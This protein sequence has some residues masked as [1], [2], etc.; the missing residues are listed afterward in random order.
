MGSQTAAGSSLALSAM[1]PSSFDAAGYVALT[2]VEIG[3]VEKLGS[4]GASF[5]KVE[6]Q[7]LKGAKQKFKGSADF[8]ALQPSIALDALDAGQILLQTASDDETQK[9]YSFRVTFPD[10]SA[11][12]FRGR[13]FG[14]PET[15]DGADSMLMATPTVEI[16]S[17]VVKVD[18]GATITPSPTLSK[19]SISP[20]SGAVGTTFT[21]SDGAVTN[22]TITGRRWLLGTTAI[23]TGT[24]VTPNAAGSLTRENTAVG[25]NGETVTS[26]STAVTV[27]AVAT[28]TL[29]L[30]PANPS[31][32]SSVAAGTLISNIA[33]V[34]SGVTPTVTPNDGRLVIAG[35]ASAGWKVVRGM[36]ALSAGTVNFSVAATGATGASGV[37]TVTAAS[38]LRAMSLAGNTYSADRSPTGTTVGAVMGLEQDATIELV[39][40]L[41]GAFAIAN[42]E[43]VIGATPA[44]TRQS[45][46]LQV[47]KTVGSLT[48]TD[49]LTVDGPI[50]VIAADTFP[51][52]AGTALETRTTT[53]GAKQWTSSVAGLFA[54]DGAGVLKPTAQTSGA[55]ATI[56]TG[57]LTHTVQAKVSTYFTSTAIF[58]MAEVVAA[59]ADANNYWTAR[60]DARY[61]RIILLQK[62]GGNEFSV[63]MSLYTLTSGQLIDIGL[64]VDA[65]EIAL[66]VNGKEV[67]WYPRGTPVANS[68]G[69]GIRVQ[70]AA[71]ATDYAT[72]RE[73]AVSTP[74]GIKIAWPEFTITNPATA[75]IDTGP[76]GSY[77]NGDANNP[78][79]APVRDPVTG[80]WVMSYSGYPT[81]GSGGDEIQHLCLARADNIDGPWTK[82]PNNPVMLA[83]PTIDGKWAFNGGFVYSAVS[84]LWVLTYGT[85]AGS[86]VAWATSPDLVTWTR[87]GKLF[88]KGTAGTWFQSG[89]F[90]SSLRVLDDGRIEC[91][92]AAKENG[93][94]FNFGRAFSSDGGLTWAIPNPAQFSSDQRLLAVFGNGSMF[95]SIIGEPCY[96]SPPSEPQQI[97]CTFD[98][99]GLGL[100][101]QPLGGRRIHGSVSFD[102]GK[103]W[104][105]RLQVRSIQASSWL[106]GMTIDSHVYNRPDGLLGMYMGATTVATTS[107]LGGGI[108]IGGSKTSTPFTSVGAAS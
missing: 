104:R 62:Q 31:V 75:D 53:A 19:P 88:A 107:P 55:F 94:G 41:G 34:P 80:K 44:L 78:A 81:R 96:V 33:N 47:R 11:R 45:R 48:R 70:A 82:D 49:T 24:T 8:G 72:W 90:D 3:Q 27:S 103:T 85:S 99:Q 26:T 38:T 58:S 91:V 65:K 71:S 28:P 86:E 68:T 16:C 79:M 64:R 76:A 17:K 22:G 67:M 52:T 42:N 46:A 9:L 59:Y 23:G 102:G 63:A 66:M 13:V 95:H 12:Y 18:A 57:S 5:A 30:S 61:N 32:A 29:S 51:G 15:A 4:F 98:A 10:G 1:L 77:D 56:E 20:T 73:F 101:N 54:I 39:D 21:A 87:R 69:V 60:L 43:I 74:C 84:N 36:S 92:T 37:L 6:F 25:T 40:T 83:D 35:D 2:Y 108:H 89:A 93:G 100:T 105:Y 14:A 97:L 106:S 7:G 50:P